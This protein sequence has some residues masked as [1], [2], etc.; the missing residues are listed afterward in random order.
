MSDAVAEIGDVPKSD[1]S[2]VLG[3]LPPK[4]TLE[5]LLQSVDSRLPAER[6]LRVIAIA[7]T[8]LAIVAI[9]FA[10]HAAQA[11]MLP[12]AAAYVVS[13]LLTPIA[14]WLGRRGL[15]EGVRAGLVVLAALMAF[16][17]ALYFVG[18][19]ALAWLDRLPGV[20]EQAQVKLEGLAAAY[21]QVQEVSKKVEEI[22]AAPNGPGDP[23]QVVVKGR[24]LSETVM[25]SAQ[26]AL[27]QIFF[28]AVLVY[29]FLSSRSSFRLKALAAQPTTQARLQTAR[30]FRDIRKKVGSYMLTMLMI[31]IGLGFATACAMAAIGMPSPIVWGLLAA[32]LNFVP[33]LGPAALAVLL[34]VSGL[35]HYESLIMA[36]APPLLWL[37]LNFIESNLVTPSLVGLRL[38][39][40]PVAI[41]V[42]V[43]L[44][45]W[46]WGPVGA[47]IAIPLVVVLK[48]VCE[49]A[50]ALR[51]V[52]VLIGEVEVVKSRKL[53]LCGVRLVGQ[54]G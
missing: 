44:F 28:A 29:F 3:A 24:T 15:S 51:M 5:A 52:G 7:T 27:V 23:L 34:G 30:V 49:A 42:S 12:L 2:F 8:I 37:A 13:I 16:F 35:V 11:V 4:R 14:D 48:T 19:P 26:V 33:Y 17:T 9:G 46:M 45:T 47:V 6:A 41:V 39:V 25:K 22:A 43:A 40:T 21:M 38:R 32:V 54:K 20:V 18:R 53:G 31:N 1:K 50:P 10:M 36:A